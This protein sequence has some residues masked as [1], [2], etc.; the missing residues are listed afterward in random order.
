MD[1]ESDA[2]IEQMKTMENEIGL[3]STDEEKDKWRED[4]KALQARFNELEEAQLQLAEAR[5]KEATGVAV[6]APMVI[7]ATKETRAPL[8][9]CKYGSSC[10][11]KKCWYGHP[12]G[13]VTKPKSQTPCLYGSACIWGD[14]CWYKHPAA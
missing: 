10:I 12:K 9:P 2:I 14:K 8:V 1:S 7:K 3:L 11:R 5:E 4:F 13:H 6:V